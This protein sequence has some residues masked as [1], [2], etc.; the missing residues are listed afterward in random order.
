[1]TRAIID[2][3]LALAV[4]GAWLGCWGFLR[5]P[6]ALDRLHCATFVNVVCGTCLTAAAFVSDGASTRA[7][8]ILAIAVLTL[9]IGAAGSHLFGRA[10]LVRTDS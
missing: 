8:K 7:L 10:V 5:Q 2:G 4:L 3:L 6:A 9:L 1:V